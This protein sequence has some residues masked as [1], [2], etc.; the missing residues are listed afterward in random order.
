MDT[1]EEHYD[2]YNENEEL[3]YSDMVRKYVMSGESSTMI[4]CPSC[5]NK[6]AVRTDYDRNDGG[7]LNDYVRISCSQCGYYRDDGLP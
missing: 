7:C 1:Q 5:K 6:E 3:N 4:E 2:E